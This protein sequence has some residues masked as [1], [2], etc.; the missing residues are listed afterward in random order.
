MSDLDPNAITLIAALAGPIV[1]YL[2]AAR[3]FSGKIETSNAKEL[4]EESRSIR[5]WSQERVKELRA[6]VARCERRIGA[7]ERENQDLKQELVEQGS[8]LI[9][10]QK[11]IA[12]LEGSVNGV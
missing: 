9:I 2:V 3:Q 8:K 6:E 4:W 1:A 7:L 12:Q 10:A 11:L 5:E